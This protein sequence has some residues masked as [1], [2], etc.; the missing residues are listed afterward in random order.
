MQ[1]EQPCCC[2]EHENANSNLKCRPA[3]RTELEDGA[4]PAQEDAQD[5]VSDQ[6]GAQ[7]QGD[8]GGRIAAFGLLRLRQSRERRA[9][10]ASL[11][12]GQPAARALL[13]LGDHMTDCELGPHICLDPAAD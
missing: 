9:L 4:D 8:W 5:G 2:P 12:L 1:V 10:S 11:L 13:S 3:V 6:L 7:E